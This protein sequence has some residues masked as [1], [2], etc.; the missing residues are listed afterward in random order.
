[1][2]V[3]VE[4][5]TVATAKLKKSRLVGSPGA[6]YWSYKDSPVGIGKVATILKAHD[7]D[8]GRDHHWEMHQDKRQDQSDGGS[9]TDPVSDRYKDLSCN[10][11]ENRPRPKI[12]LCANLE[13]CRRCA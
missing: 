11:S 6:N 8:N 1:M 5:I 3:V 12:K 10:G 4:N 7:E 13:S 2:S 9:R